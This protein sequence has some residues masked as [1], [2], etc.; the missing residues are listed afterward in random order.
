[1]VI[2]RPRTFCT[3]EALDRALQV[4]WRKGYEG[5]TICDL[6]EAMGIKPPSLYAA[7]GSKEELFRKVLDRY[8]D[9]RADFVQEAL[10]EPNARDA[11]AHLLRGTADFLTEKCNP[12]GCLLVQGVAG[13]GDH[14]Q[15]IRDEMKARR[16]SG[17]KKI[18]ERLK[19]ARAEGDLAKAADPASFARYLITVIEGMAVQAAS[20]ATRT[21]LRRVAETAMKAWP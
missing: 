16:A 18:C 15:C 10:A 8:A 1:V 21:E 11:V 9:A 4:F 20:G 17:E 5:A 7:F 6:T 14:A 13:V 12:A 2:G 3:E 19:R